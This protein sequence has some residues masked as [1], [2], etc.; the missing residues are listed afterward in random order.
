MRMAW[1]LHTYWW[2]RG[3]WNEA[4]QRIQRLLANPAGV[5][6][7]TARAA[8]LILAGNYSYLL[9]DFAAGWA[10]LQ[11]SQALSRE[12]GAEGRPYLGWSRVIHGESLISHDKVL[13]QRLF[14][15]GIQLLHESGDSWR[16]G[17]SLMLY[18]DL[19]RTQGHLNLALDLHGESLEVLRRV[20]DVLGIAVATSSLGL[21]L[22]A[23]GDYAS[24]R[25]HFEEALAIFRNAGLVVVIG[26]TLGSIG[27]IAFIQGDYHLAAACFE[28]GL[29]IEEE[30]GS[31]ERRGWM[32][33]DFA[34]TVGHLG[35][36]T[37]AASLWQAAIALHD[38]LGSVYGMAVCVLGLAG[39][40]SQPERATQ[41][42]SAAQTA[43]EVSMEAIEPHYRIEHERQTAAVRAALGAESFALAWAAGRAMS[44]KQA[45]ALARATLDTPQP[46]GQIPSTPTS[47]PVN[48]RRFGGL[49]KREREVATLIAQGKSNR[50]IAQTLIVSEYTVASHVSNILSKLEFSSR[51]QIVSWAIEKGLAK[52]P[53]P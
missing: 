17:I 45:I 13:S 34:L 22:Y 46:N 9:S 2:A 18:G 3:Y 26:S 49:T 47:L 16:L 15:E 10:W 4:R 33:A 41:L 7:T 38:E 8:A 25:I 32:L 31:R 14:E 20:G 6:P 43:F 52:L 44:M 19:A 28:E 30:I 29:T 39:L 36:W 42:L 51:T 35:D 11:E 50:E 27:H 21:A 48:Q 40:Q 12:L 37:R 5:E 24:A 23:L 1:G 53:I